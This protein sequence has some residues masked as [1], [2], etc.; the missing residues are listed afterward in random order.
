M[1]DYSSERHPTTY[2]AAW[3]YLHQVLTEESLCYKAGDQPDGELRP[4]RHDGLNC[5]EAVYKAAE[6][7]QEASDRMTIESIMAVA[8]LVRWVAKAARC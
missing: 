8:N 5:G 2:G 4:I 1:A 3:G 6:R 7:L